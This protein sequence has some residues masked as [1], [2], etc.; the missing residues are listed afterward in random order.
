MLKSSISFEGFFATE[1]TPNL[2]LDRENNSVL[3]EQQAS[4][5]QVIQVYPISVGMGH[6][7]SLL[8]SLPLRR[9]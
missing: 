4:R 6:P 2:I 5:W 9:F 3:R 8:G 7:W 1:V